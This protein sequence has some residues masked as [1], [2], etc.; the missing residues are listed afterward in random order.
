MAAAFPMMRAVPHTLATTTT[1]PAA[2]AMFMAVPL[3]AVAS[4][5]AALVC[6]IGTATTLALFAATL[7]LAVVRMVAA[8]AGR[9]LLR[10]FCIFYYRICHVHSFQ[11]N[12]ISPSRLQDCQ[13]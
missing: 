4:T 2:P 5:T 7:V 9:I 13:N 8:T 10:H 3:L 11:E 6:L 12:K 1:T